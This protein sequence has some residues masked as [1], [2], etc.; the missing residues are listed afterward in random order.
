MAMA[1][2]VAVQLFAMQEENLKTEHILVSVWDFDAIGDDDPIGCGVLEVGFLLAAARASSGVA[3]FEVPL[4]YGGL[5]GVGKLTGAF[6]VR[7]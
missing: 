3:E 2:L 6:V 4:M 7:A 1:P 5:P